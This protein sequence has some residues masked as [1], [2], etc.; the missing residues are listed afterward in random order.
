MT[1]FNHDPE[2]E[3]TPEPEEEPHEDWARG[4]R[5]DRADDNPEPDS[6]GGEE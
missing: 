6:E 5:P 1:H 4:D 2:P 3:P